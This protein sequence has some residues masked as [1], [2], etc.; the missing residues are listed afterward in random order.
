LPDGTFEPYTAHE[1][2]AL[3]FVYAHLGQ[4][5]P[6]GDLPAAHE[7]L[8]YWLWEQPQNAQPW[9]TKLSP[10][11]QSMMQKMFSHRVDDMSPEILDRI[12]E[13]ETELSA[14]WPEGKMG[15]LRVP[16]YILHGSTDDII[17]ST[18]SLWLEK[19]VPRGE[20]AEALITPAFAH[21]DPERS[22]DMR[23]ELRLVDFIAKFLRAAGG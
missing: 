11:G 20:I 18:E 14:I 5:S 13:D 16:V 1:Y 3:V 10:E 2:G 22:V 7:A 6:A 4:F 21:V 23:D 12:K 8:K 17:P 15:N 9:L 19:D